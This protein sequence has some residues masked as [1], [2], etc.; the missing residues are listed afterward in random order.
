MSNAV[1]QSLDTEGN[2]QPLSLI[3]LDRTRL[4][5]ICALEQVC[6][7]FP[8]SETLIEGEFG[9]DVSLRVGLE[10]SESLVAYSLSHL[11]EDEL[12]ILN[13]AVSPSQ[14]RRGVGRAMLAGLL[15]FA[16][17]RGV[18]FA[19]LEVRPSNTPAINLYSSL[20][21]YRTGIRKSYYRNNGED[22][23]LFERRLIAK[24]ANDLQRL[25]AFS[26]TA[27]VRSLI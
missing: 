1:S 7:P 11:V 5:E 27:P 21:F 25:S 18:K 23:L 9:K 12:H 17:K 16:L 6:Y 3:L 4:A 22:A 13:F 15:G 19:F 10:Q 26:T 8:W 14:Q 2:E 20:G 24:D